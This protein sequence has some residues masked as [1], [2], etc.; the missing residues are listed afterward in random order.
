MFVDPSKDTPAILTAAASFVA[1]AALPV[2]DAD[3]PV[4][5]W[6]RVATLAAA[7]VPED[8]LL[9]FKVVNPDPLPV[10]VPLERVILPLNVEFAAVILRF[11]PLGLSMV[12]VPL[13]SIFNSFTP[14][15]LVAIILYEIKIFIM[16]Y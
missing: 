5:F 9:P 6:F 7:I 8:I 16:I 12:G 1:V 2:H 14:N 3:D 4:V 11:P 10:I 13:P 15:A